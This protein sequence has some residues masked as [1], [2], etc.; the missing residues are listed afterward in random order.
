MKLWTKAAAYGVSAVVLASAIIFSGSALGLLS[1]RSSGLLSV[2]LTDPPSVPDGVTAVYISYSGMAVHA[3]GFG[4]G[5]WVAVSGAGTVDTLKL[6]ILSQTISTGVIPSLTYDVIRFNITGASVEFM[7]KN[8]SAKVSSGTITVPFVSGLKVNSSIPAAAL[9]DIQPTILNLGTQ[10][11]PNFNMATGARA[12]Q[13]PSKDVG[14]SLKNMGSTLNL[15]GN[16]WFNAFRSHHSST[17]DSTEPTLTADSL[18]FSE[19]NRG[20]DPLVVR[21]VIVT[22]ATRGASHGPLD[23]VANGVVFSVGSDGTLT[24]LSG[25]PDQ[26]GSLLGGR[27]YTLA[28]GATFQFSYS[29]TLTTLLGGSGITNGAS[30]YVTAI[31]SE[32]LSVQTVVAS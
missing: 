28:P 32:T 3:E 24:L 27:G 21:M 30:Y 11:G 4:D 20:D 19:T 5:G 15:Q 6:I 13:V 31:G 23:S 1:T 17:L 14:D 12:L 26:V 16:S 2:M 18:S 8:Y 29:G 7:G 10:F 22:P 9:I 25:S